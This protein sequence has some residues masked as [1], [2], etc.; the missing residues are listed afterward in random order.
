MTAEAVSHA[1]R[2]LEVEPRN[3]TALA[4]LR[5]ADLQKGAYHAARARYEVGYP[6][7]FAQGA[8]TVGWWNHVAAIDVALVLQTQGDREQADLLLD[9]A[10]RL[11]RPIPRLGVYGVG[12]ADVRIHALRGKKARALAAVA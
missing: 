8:P 12:I 9:G 7:L 3:S 2:S 1:K 4:I 6:E 11:I 5:D 10:A